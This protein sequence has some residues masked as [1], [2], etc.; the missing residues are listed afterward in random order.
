MDGTEDELLYESEDENIV[1]VDFPNSHWDPYY[2]ETVNDN[3]NDGLFAS[4]DD[5]YD[6]L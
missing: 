4:D 5:L 3:L 6:E 2:D 1:K